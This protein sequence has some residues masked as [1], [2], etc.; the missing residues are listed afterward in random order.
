M[1]LREI[2]QTGE[3]S[4]RSVMGEQPE[5]VDGNFSCDYNELTSLEGAP[6]SVGGSFYCHYNQLTSLEGAPQSVGGNFYCN[7]NQLTSLKDVHKHVKEVGGTFSCN[8]ARSHVL[9]LFLVKG[10]QEVDL[11]NDQ[12]NGIVNKHLPSKGRTSM[13]A[14]AEELI[15][16]GFEEYAQV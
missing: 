15:E 9:G 14:C 1:K 7:H 13:V 3:R 2:K 16:A 6:K 4:V 12:L 5:H 8:T 10:L 11:D